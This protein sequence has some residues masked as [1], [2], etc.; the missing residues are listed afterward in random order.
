MGLKGYGNLSAWDFSRSSY[1]HIDRLVPRGKDYLLDLAFIAAA[2]FVLVSSV[3]ARHVTQ[4]YGVRMSFEIL[5]HYPDINSTTS[6]MVFEGAVV[7]VYHFLPSF[8]IYDLYL[9]RVLHLLRN[10]QK[11]ISFA[12]VL[13]E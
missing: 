5:K 6:Y 9:S 10:L 1:G 4:D 13:R 12:P 3:C 7:K 11:S 2:I 8:I